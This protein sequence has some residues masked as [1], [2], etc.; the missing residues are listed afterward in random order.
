MWLLASAKLIPKLS[1]FLPPL[2]KATFLAISS[3]LPHSYSTTPTLAVVAIAAVIDVPSF[4]PQ[5][6]ADAKANLQ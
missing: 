5:V 2:Q 3:T 1:N 6:P 4:P